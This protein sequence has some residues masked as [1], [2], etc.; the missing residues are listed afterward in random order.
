[1][2]NTQTGY[3][4]V[5]LAGLLTIAL[6]A[7]GAEA[8]WNAYM[9]TG[10]RLMNENRYA[11]AAASFR[12][13][14]DRAQGDRNASQLGIGLDLLGIA[15]DIAGRDR[16]AEVPFHGSIAALELS[17]DTPHAALIDARTDLAALY[18][19]L[20]HY[21][22][23]HNQAEQARA[24]LNQQDP[25]DTVRSSMVLALLAA[26]EIRQQRTAEAEAHLKEA[27]EMLERKGLGQTRQWI[28]AANNLAALWTR[29]RPENS[30]RILIQALAR[31]KTVLHANEDDLVMAQIHVNLAQLD[32]TLR[33][34]DESELHLRPGL[35][36]FERILGPAHPMTGDALRQ[37]AALC[38]ATG[39]KTIAK[40]YEGRAKKFLRSKA[41]STTAATVDVNDLRERRR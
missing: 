15:L 21:N 7:S 31:S 22:W 25:A 18:L 23:A 2:C 8:S 40:D 11:E 20:G 5:Q 28:T 29:N 33:R 34:F 36:A 13:A 9:E 27:F 16:E 24:A 17:D 26:I 38:R 10:Q 39:R 37:Y 14:S 19:K 35:E 3:R 6:A 12:S 32:F 30:R 4:C 41:N 1:M